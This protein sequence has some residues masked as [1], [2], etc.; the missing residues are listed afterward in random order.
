MAALQVSL[1]KTLSRDRLYS[2]IWF[3][4]LPSQFFGLA[5]PLIPGPP[6]AWMSRRTIDMSKPSQMPSAQYWEDILNAR[7]VGLQGDLRPHFN[8]KPALIIFHP[9]SIISPSSQILYFTW[10]RRFRVANI[11]SVHTEWYEYLLMLQFYL[12]LILLFPLMVF[13]AEIIAIYV[14]L[15]SPAVTS[16]CLTAR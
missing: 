14:V 15:L 11:S 1:P 3:N 9:F 5:R 2:F 12:G 10:K 7:L 8:H 13:A 16:S 6:A 4:I